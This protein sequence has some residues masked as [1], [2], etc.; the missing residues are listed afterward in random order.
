MKPG[1]SN[2]PLMSNDIMSRRIFPM[3][4]SG[5]KV[6]LVV[7]DNF[8]YDQWRMWLKKSATSLR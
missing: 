4:D 1:N 7:I 2:R 5:E 3:L 6:F 8:R